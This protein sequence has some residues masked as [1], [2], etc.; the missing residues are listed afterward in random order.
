MIRKNHLEKVLTMSKVV[1]DNDDLDIYFDD[2][3]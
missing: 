3:E 2:I 1:K